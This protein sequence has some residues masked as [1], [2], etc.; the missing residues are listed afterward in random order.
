METTKKNRSIDR[1][2]FKSIYLPLSML[3]F[4]EERAAQL[5]VSVNSIIVDLIAR[6]IER[7]NIAR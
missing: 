4:L 3:E 2:I 1:K 5:G 6:E 7:E